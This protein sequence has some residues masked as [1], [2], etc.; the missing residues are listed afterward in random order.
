RLTDSLELEEEPHRSL[1]PVETQGVLAVYR[2]RLW[3]GLRV[4][5]KLFGGRADALNAGLNVASYP[6]V[7]VADART[8]LYPSALTVAIQRFEIEPELAALGA[9]VTPQAG[10]RL[11]GALQLI[12]HARQTATR[13]CQGKLHAL[14]RL[15]DGFSVLH[16]RD[17]VALGGFKADAQ[18]S[19]ALV[20]RL[21][22]HKLRRREPCS[23]RFPPDPAGEVRAPSTLLRQLLQW[24]TTQRH[25][26]RLLTLPRFSLLR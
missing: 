20:L 24:T 11:L 1:G 17:A 14:T 3:P 5:T 19:T 21:R 7:C 9:A 16:R 2:S 25:L 26:T 12:T 6:L 8:R 13:T 10:S 4:V 15:S 23:V 22:D 18:S